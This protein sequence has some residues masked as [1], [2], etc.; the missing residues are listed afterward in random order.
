MKL[1][2][3]S[4]ADINNYGDILFSHVFKMELSKRIP[5]VEIDFYTPTTIDLEGYH[6]EG[7]RR[8]KV[9]N[10]Y[11]G[12]FLAGGEV[13]HLFDERTWDPIYSK[14][15][16]TI[17]SKLASDTV[18]DWATCKSDFKAWLSVGVRPFGDRWD[19]E[20]TDNTIA[21]L[22][23]VGCRGI[24]SKKILEGS[25]FEAFNPKIHLTPDL[26]W[27]F[28][29]Y[30][31]DLNLKG[32][33]Y[34]D[35]VEKEIKY[36]L[37]QVHNINEDEAKLIARELL[38][39]KNESGFQIVMMPV[40][41]LWQDEVYLDQINEHANHEFIVLKNDLTVVEMLDIIVHA[42]LT[43]TSSLHV[44]ITA[45]AAGIP[46]SVFNKWQGS[47]LQDLYGLQFRTEFLFSDLKEFRLIF[48][49]LNAER[50]HAKSLQL[51]ADFMK[52]KLSEVFDDLAGRL[53][54][55]QRN[56]V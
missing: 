11:H 52:S 31:D 38:R 50:L 49:Q 39:I 33:K 23:Y 14:Q 36:L 41:H 27:L 43:I 18:W 22:D 3:M 1:A 8:D 19:G 37:F 17:V 51:Y 2:M 25:N 54:K 10:R 5:G 13:V 20:K 47:K 28:P 32:K 6:Y 46:A 42:K 12:V 21:A 15:K 55:K 24:L 53:T 45:L 35:F 44:A 7:Y 4:F 34:T 29:K 56:N 9:D 16:K 26:G 48:E 40:I 30:L